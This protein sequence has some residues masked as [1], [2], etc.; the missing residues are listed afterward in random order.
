MNFNGALSSV[1]VNASLGIRSNTYNSIGNADV[2]F[3]RN[4]IDFFY[5]RNGQVETNTGVSLYST[6]AK[7]NNI[8]TAGDTNMIFSRNG[9]EYFRL[10]SGYTGGGGAP[11]NIIDVSNTVGV[12]SSWLFGSAVA[13]R[14]VDTD[15]EFLGAVSAGSAWG[16]LYMKYEHILDSLHIYSDVELEQD[17]VLYIHQ[18]T[19]KNSWI[20]SSNTAGVNHTS[21]I[22]QDPNGD[23]RIFADGGVRLYVTPS[24]VSVPPPYTLEG[25]L[26]DTSDL[27]KKY[28]IKSIEHN[29][30]DI[31]KQVEPKTFKM[32]DEKELGITKNHIGFIADEIMNV[33]PDEWQ[34]IVM[35]DN[36][37]VKKLS[38]IK[39]T[40]ILWGVCREQQQKIEW[41]ESSVYELQEAVKALSKPKAKAKAKSKVEK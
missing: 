25:D 20:T 11:T 16:K 27:T 9:V 40:G 1:D 30:T 18:E 14:S 10:G 5:L 36:E 37:G 3:R 15:T 6:D 7:L 4:N 33:I 41:L 26:V 12:S 17:K 22:N 34:N 2:A 28:D 32:E 39:L 23:V 31:V 19:S 8:N 35:T 24:K 38:Y 29:F 13:N 21:I